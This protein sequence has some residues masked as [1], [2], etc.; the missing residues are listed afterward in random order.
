M[1]FVQA[2]VNCTYRQGDGIGGAEQF[3]GIKETSMICAQECM[4]RKKNDD[5]INGATYSTTGTKKCYCEKGMIERND[6]H[7]WMSCVFSQPRKFFTVNKCSFYFS[8]KN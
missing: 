3:I 7:V 8:Y 1:H 5:S 6:E 4:L 2:P